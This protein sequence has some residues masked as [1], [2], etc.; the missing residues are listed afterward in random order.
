MYVDFNRVFL[1]ITRQ[2]A[3][4]KVLVTNIGGFSSSYN[5]ILVPDGDY[6]AHIKTFHLNLNLRRLSCSSR[7]SLGLLPPSDAQRDRFFRIF[8]LPST[9]ANDLISTVL[10]LVRLI[11]F[12]LNILGRLPGKQCSDGL[13]CNLTGNSLKQYAADYGP[14]VFEVI[15]CKHEIFFVLMVLQDS[16]AFCEPPIFAAIVGKIL[17]LRNKLNATGAQVILSL[18]FTAVIFSPPDNQRSV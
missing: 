6:E 7:S 2:T 11:Q 14:F 3:Q 9:T 12:S 13:L 15:C 18:S 1:I 5:L 8:H 10:G 16:N 4:G 17:S